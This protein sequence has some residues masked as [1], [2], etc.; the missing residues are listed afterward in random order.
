VDQ[1][2][3]IHGV[4][5]DY[6]RELGFSGATSPNGPECCAECPGMLELPYFCALKNVPRGVQKAGGVLFII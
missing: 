5:P 4:R 2:A 3:R 6:M 1:Q